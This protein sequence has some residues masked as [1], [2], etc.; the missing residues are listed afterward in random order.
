MQNKGFTKRLLCLL[1]IVLIAVTACMASGC[2]SNPTPSAPSA[3]PEQTAIVK[4]EGNTVFTFIA[5]DLEGKTTVFEI[6]T[7]ETLVG[8][9]LQQVGLIEGEEGA[10][11]LYVKTVNGVTIDWDTHGKY[12]AFFIGEDYAPTGVDQTDVVAGTTYGFA[13]AS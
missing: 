2:N 9:A 12:W 5:A 4:G 7:N 6:H 10:Y 8:A 13:P 1:C 11:G 3:E